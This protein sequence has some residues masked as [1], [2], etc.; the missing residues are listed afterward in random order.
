MNEGELD[1]V[2]S[3]GQQRQSAKALGAHHPPAMQ[4]DDWDDASDKKRHGHRTGS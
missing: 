3:R 1:R 2:D 4:E